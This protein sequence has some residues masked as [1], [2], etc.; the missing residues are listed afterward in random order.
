MSVLHHE[1]VRV[2]EVSK[3]EA[4]GMRS[5]PRPTESPQSLNPTASPSLSARRRLGKGIRWLMMESSRT[6]RPPKPTGRRPSRRT[7]PRGC[8]PRRL[9]GR[10][11]FVLVAHTTAAPAGTAIGAHSRSSE[12]THE[13]SRVGRIASRTLAV[14]G[15]IC[16]AVAGL[17]L[18]VF[19]GGLA[20]S[21]ESGRDVASHA[22][23]IEQVEQE[24]SAL[25]EKLRMRQPRPVAQGEFAEKGDPGQNVRQR[26]PIRPRIVDPDEAARETLHE[27]LFRLRMSK[28]SEFSL[29]ASIRH[30]HWF[31]GPPLLA[32]CDQRAPRRHSR[33]YFS[34]AYPLRREGRISDSR[35]SF[36]RNG[37]PKL[38]GL[39]HQEWSWGRCS[40]R[41]RSSF[42]YRTQKALVGPVSA[43]TLKR[44]VEREGST[45]PRCSGGARTAPG[46]RRKGSM[47]RW[48]PWRKSSLDPPDDE[49]LY[50]LNRWSPRA[51]TN[52]PSGISLVMTGASWADPQFRDHR[53]ARQAS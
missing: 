27:Q 20:W 17:Q 21:F 31:F 14:I 18:S 23:R 43:A 34:S 15:W 39:A 47:R 25:E 4:E 22:A 28:P 36:R 50:L 48:S 53:M 46:S 6:R 35:G 40:N 7:G 13:D 49:A 12:R 38:R 19:A 42:D 24:I 41:R 29:T 30:G 37:S 11:R 33:V 44:L 3:S 45:R 32:G 1:V 26:G 8:G 9:A 10:G 2:P 16:I 51:A 5:H 52:R